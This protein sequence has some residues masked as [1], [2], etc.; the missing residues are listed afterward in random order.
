MQRLKDCKAGKIRHPVTN[1][2]RNTTP[3]KH[4]RVLKDC[5]AGKIRHPVTKRCRKEKVVKPRNPRTKNITSNKNRAGFS[6]QGLRD[7]FDLLLHE[8]R[9]PIGQR[10]QERTGRSTPTIQ[11][12][13]ESASDDML[14][15]EM[16]GRGFTVIY[17]TPT[18]DSASF[19][20]RPPSQEPVI[21]ILI[22][23]RKNGFTPSSMR[24]P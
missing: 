14:Q 2:C 5:V 17:P 13:I 19:S 23:R 9:Q 22:P 10:K 4:V 20:I 1:R 15:Q 6:N 12:C 16:I 11:E 7:E 3:K 21:N 18:I 24:M 8:M